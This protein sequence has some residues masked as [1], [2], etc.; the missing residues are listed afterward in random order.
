M[1]LFHRKNQLCM[2]SKKK[3]IKKKAVPKRKPSYSRIKEQPAIR[4]IVEVVVRNETSGDNSNINFTGHKILNTVADAIEAVK[5]YEFVIKIKK[6]SNIIIRRIDIENATLY[7]DDLKDDPVDPTFWLS[8]TSSKVLGSTFL[9]SV[10]ATGD[11][12]TSTTFNLTC[13]DKKVFDT[14]QNIDIK[15]N[16]RGLYLNKQVALP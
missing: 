11:T 2:T 1:V 5:P 16:G 9:L 4:I 7:F 13:D 10:E 8:K 3:A 14:D 6:I 15:S 12:F